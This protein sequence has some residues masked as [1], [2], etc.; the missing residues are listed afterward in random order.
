MLDLT[1]AGPCVVSQAGRLLV[2][3]WYGPPSPADH[4]AAGVSPAKAHRASLSL[5]DT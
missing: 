1:D 4:G 5:R 2:R 3:D